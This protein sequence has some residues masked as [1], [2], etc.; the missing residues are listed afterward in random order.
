MSYWAEIPFDKIYLYIDDSIEQAKP[1]R[2]KNFLEDKVDREVVLKKNFLRS[3][4]QDRLPRKIAGAKVRDKRERKM[5]DP[6]SKEIDLEK[7]VIKGGKELLGIIY[8]AHELNK[9][10]RGLL[11]EKERKEH[12]V[13]IT[14]RLIGTLETHESRYHI[15]AVLN[16][17]PS[18]ISI[19]GIVEGPAKPRKY[20]L[21]DE[22]KREEIL[23][24][25]PIEHGDERMDSALKAYLLQTIFWRLEGDPFCEREGCPL[26]NSHWQREVLKN[27]VNGKLCER[28]K[29]RLEKFKKVC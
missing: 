4:Y 29:R 23:D 10:S 24:F 16:S 28:H 17:I 7:K 14:K 3:K 21:A 25:R 12:T 19:S 9:I 13:I 1:K 11:S 22:T 15:R 20:Y 8:D 2:L 6:L 5:M 26:Y 18:I 27:Q